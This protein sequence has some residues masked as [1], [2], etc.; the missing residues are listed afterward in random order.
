MA[1]REQQAINDAE[2]HNPENWA[3]VGPWK[4][5]FSTRDSRLFV[6][7]WWNN[8][9]SKKGDITVSKKGDITDLHTNQ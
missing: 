9:L 4:V 7:R 2:W 1:N 5:Y 8:W 6:P 3:G